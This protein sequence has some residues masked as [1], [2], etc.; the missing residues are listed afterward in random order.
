MNVYLITYQHLGCEKKHLLSKISKGNSG[1]D[2]DPYHKDISVFYSRRLAEEMLEVIQ[3]EFQDE[4]DHTD[5]FITPL[6]MF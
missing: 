4:Y 2:I 3:D 5:F 6:K 1:W